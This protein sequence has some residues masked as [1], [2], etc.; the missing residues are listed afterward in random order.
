MFN[1]PCKKCLVQATCKQRCNEFNEYSFL[2]TRLKSIFTGVLAAS[3]FGIA[4]STINYNLTFMILFLMLAIIASIFM[5]KVIR[6]ESRYYI[7][8][9]EFM[10]Y[11]S[12]IFK[13]YG[14][15]FPMNRRIKF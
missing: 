6:K 5:G 4:T 11:E 7:L 2:L 8:T 1:I 10:I 9:E 14:I 15:K 13:K 12:P 3:G